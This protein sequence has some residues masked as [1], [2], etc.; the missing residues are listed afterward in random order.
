MVLLPKSVSIVLTGF[1][2][3]ILII[4]LSLL[5]MAAESD[6]LFKIRQFHSD[7]TDHLVQ[8][9]QDLGQFWPQARIA[10]PSQSWS[11]YSDI[12]NLLPGQEM[13]SHDEELIMNKSNS[14]KN[15]EDLKAINCVKNRDIVYEDDQTNN[16][17]K[18]NSVDIQV[19]NQQSCGDVFGANDIFEASVDRVFETGFLKSYGQGTPYATTGYEH[20]GNYMNI[21]VTGIT[22]SAINTVPDGSAVAN[23][24]II[25]K[26]VQIIVCPPE[27]EEKLK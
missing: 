3:F 27:V 10:Y 4:N 16:D 23:S 13:Q 8:P 6:P 19:D 11:P 24:N 5:G 7:F 2:F 25:I 14:E 1:L 26:P 9:R 15:V 21:G 22:V 17:G 20:L 18:G 12:A